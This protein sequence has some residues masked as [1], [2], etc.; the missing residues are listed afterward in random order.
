MLSVF[1]KAVRDARKMTLWLS[2][3]FFLYIV[4]VIAFYPSL[5]EQSETMNELLASYPEGFLSAFYGTDASEIDIADPGGYVHSQ[6][7]LFLILILG[8]VAIAQAFNAFTNAERDG[9]MDILLSL[10]VTR[11]QVLVGRVLATVVCMI[12][13]LAASSVG[14]WV[15]SQ[16]FPE[17]QVSLGDMILMM[18]GMLPALMVVMAFA[19]MLACLIPSRYKFAGAIAYLF[20]LGS[21]IFFS[22]ALSIEDLNDLQPIFLFNYYNAADMMHK[23]IEWGDWALLGAVMAVY[24][25]VAY[26]GVEH[27]ELGV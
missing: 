9:T 10:P 3:G 19:Y 22:L 24:L 5:L 25:G 12:A 23:G 17:F 8:A 14:L 11:R 16:A 26:W 18:F 7:A 13:V 2:I 15:G 6:F 4:M 20:L 1:R 27:K 21:Y